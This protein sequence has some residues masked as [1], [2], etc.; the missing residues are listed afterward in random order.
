MKKKLS[1]VFLLL[2]FL[3]NNGNNSSSMD[4]YAPVMTCGVPKSEPSNLSIESREQIFAYDTTFVMN[5]YR[6]EHKD[7]SDDRLQILDLEFKKFAIAGSVSTMPLPMCNKDLDDYWHTFILFTH[8][9]KNFCKKLLGKFMHHVPAEN[10]EP[11]SIE[12]KE[13]LI[14]LYQKLFNHEPNQEFWPLSKNE[15]FSDCTSWCGSI[16]GRA[17]NFNCESESCDF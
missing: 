2:N 9:Y 14:N 17:C 12:Q 6:K 16:C 4:C 10:P 15:K 3:N 1:I 11:V 13:N 7:V 8:E 5:R